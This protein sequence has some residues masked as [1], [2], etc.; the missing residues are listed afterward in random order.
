MRY[1]A[2]VFIVPNYAFK[3]DECLSPSWRERI[4]A[5]WE[6]FGVKIGDS[7]KMVEIWTISDSPKSEDRNEYS[8]NWSS[9]KPPKKIEFEGNWPHYFPLDLLPL[10]EGETF[11]IKNNKDEFVLKANQLDYR[12][13]WKDFGEMLMHVISR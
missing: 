2:N 4:K 8:D 12:Y 10:G 5:E 13:N 9:H 6:N 3:V 1:T 7:T 11:T